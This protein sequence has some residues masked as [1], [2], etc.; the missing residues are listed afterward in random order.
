MLY[1]NIFLWFLIVLPLLVFF[2]I[3]IFDSNRR[4]ITLNYFQSKHNSEK[5][6]L[7]RVVNFLGFAVGFLLGL[8]T[9]IQLTIEIISQLR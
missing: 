4:K 2:L 9:L 5:S 6:T 3:L 8:F 1:F 7:H